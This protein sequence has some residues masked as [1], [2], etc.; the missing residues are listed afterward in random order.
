MKTKAIAVLDVGKTNKK[1]LIFSKS[2]HILEKKCKPFGE[3]V[4]DE[5]RRLEQP[6]AVLEWLLTELSHY[7]Q[8][9][10]I[11]IIS[12]S[13]HGAMG[14]CVDEH[15]EITCPPIAYT[16]EPGSDFCDSFYD[17]FGDRT[18]LQSRTATAE[19]GQM[20]NFGKMAYYWTQRYPAE[21]ENTKHILPYPQYFGY[22]MTGKAA[23]ETTMLGCHSYLY[24]HKNN[25]YSD[26]VQK[27]GLA[28][29]LPKPIK[30][31]WEIL[32]NITPDMARRCGL[33]KNCLVTL[34]VHDSNATLLVYLLNEPGNYVLNSTGTW[35]VVMKPAADVV[36][37]EEEL[38][39]TVYYNQDV[40]G[41]PVKTSIFMAGQEY[42]TY[43]E[44]FTKIHKRDDLPPININ[45]YQS[46]FNTCRTFVL[47]SVVRG[48]G[49]F[50]HS[51]PRLIH[52]DQ[53]IA[54]EELKSSFKAIEG[55]PD[56]ELSM[57]ALVSSLVIQTSRALDFSGY[58]DGGDIFVE[59]GFK[60]NQPYLELLA[61][62]YP[63]SR[64]YKTSI[65]EATATGAAILGLAAV[66]EKRPDELKV[67]FGIDKEWIQKPAELFLGNYKNE[68]YRYVTES[69]SSHEIGG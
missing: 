66:E 17:A 5:G 27:L 45:L 10:E 51:Q 41:R 40:F 1:I 33:S 23:A 9:Y 68:F 44:L 61:A 59:G 58:Q 16:N 39:K 28:E 11:E 46:L 48:A 4:N 31:S 26:V 54:L 24:D 21:I 49:L 53:R 7:S 25:D 52:G 15:G 8:R 67:D 30:K 50:P 43:T 65:D 13:T 62:C 12:V 19:I 60:E 69:K 47:P 57:A 2:L 56:Y 55:L 32:G 3:L 63:R 18:T 38:G 37:K 34:G 20:I 14:V 36:F 22:K 6:E 64:V 29:K 42:E 35:C